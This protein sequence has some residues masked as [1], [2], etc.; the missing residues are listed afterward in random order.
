MTSEA[1][2]VAALEGTP[3]HL[4][5]SSS[6]RQIGNRRQRVAAIRRG[7]VKISNPLPVP[8]EGDDDFPLRRSTK[9]Y[10]ISEE[11]QREQEQTELGVRGPLPVISRA[12]IGRAFTTANTPRGTPARRR[13]PTLE[14]RHSALVEAGGVS[15]RRYDFSNR[16]PF[17]PR[18]NSPANRSRGQIRKRGNPVKSAF[19]RLFRKSTRKEPRQS[20]TA[21]ATRPVARAGHAPEHHR[22]DPGLLAA[23]LDTSLDRPPQDDYMRAASAPIS[24]IRKNTLGSYSSSG[25]EGRCSRDYNSQHRG[26]IAQGGSRTRRASFPTVT[27]T[28]L[29][30]RPAAAQQSSP[31]RSE[32]EPEASGIGYA[33]SSSNSRR[34]SRSAGDVR[35]SGEARFWQSETER[36]VSDQIRDWRQSLLVEQPSSPLSPMSTA[37]QFD[38]GNG[39][40]KA[41]AADASRRPSVDEDPMPDGLGPMKITE[42][43]NLVSRVGS[44][45]CQAADLQS[46]V[47]ELRSAPRITCSRSSEFIL[48][49]APKRRS[50]RDRQSRSTAS[51]KILPNA[52]EHVDGTTQRERSPPQRES[53]DAHYTTPVRSSGRYVDIQTALTPP[54]DPGS[55]SKHPTSAV[56]ATHVA[57]ADADVVAYYPDSATTILPSLSTPHYKHLL[58]LVQAEQFARKTLEEKITQLQSELRNL[59][60]SPQMNPRQHGPRS[61][62]AAYPTPSP[63]PAE[64]TFSRRRGGVSQRYLPDIETSNQPEHADG[65]QLGEE[66]DEDEEEEEEEEGEY[67]H[68]SEEV[69]A[70]PTEAKVLF[71]PNERERSLAGQLRGEVI[72]E[73]RDPAGRALSLGQL[74][75]N[76]GRVRTAAA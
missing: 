14:V 32:P 49:D 11:P 10:S 67:A 48:E 38:Q 68:S 4:D 35:A 34:R 53:Y 47:T 62:V 30:P 43:A 23:Q 24:P 40:N 6:L 58:G 12:D 5:A 59:Q 56:R 27:W 69:Y 46:A 41:S 13:S 19:Q 20:D 54:Q 44:L 16:P 72:E 17:D 33:V 15:N 45:E 8:A 36:R 52:L 21:E 55:D 22:S 18:P 31:K 63:E 1:F 61:S 9:V 66:C 39:P 50:F 75:R 64:P 70:T 71:L 65:A 25:L 2:E 76:H 28:E 42:A 60:R 3:S 7:D 73:C 37:N 51:L 29:A 57:G 74:T 26:S